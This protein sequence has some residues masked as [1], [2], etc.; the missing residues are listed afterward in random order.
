ME[1][2][3]AGDTF[4]TFQKA[5]YQSL[6]TIHL[7]KEQQD[8]LENLRGNPLRGSKKGIRSMHT[9]EG[10]AS[11]I[12]HVECVDRDRV[13]RP[14]TW[15]IKQYLSKVSRNSHSS[16]GKID[17]KSKPQQKYHYDIHLYAYG[18][19]YVHVCCIM[20]LNLAC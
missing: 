14:W 12:I 13:S 4:F 7:E 2:T 20:H 19:T 5:I 1:R 16:Q 9:D 8:L 10:S 3:P 18:H 11:S 6:S 17:A 15:R